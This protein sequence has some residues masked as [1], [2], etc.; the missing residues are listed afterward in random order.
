MEIE[1]WENDEEWGPLR[2]K[3][4]QVIDVV[5]LSM[6]SIGSIF[7]SPSGTAPTSRYRILEGQE[8]SR[9]TYSELF[10]VIGTT[11][12]DGDGASTFNLPD[13]RGKT[14]FGLNISETEFDTLGESGGLKEV[15]L[16]AA[17]SGIRDHAHN[18]GG[19]AEG[20]G[21]IAPIMKTS[22][23]N[24]GNTTGGAINIDGNPA[25]TGAQSATDAHTNMPPYVV[26]NWV[27]RVL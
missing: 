19:Y 23:T 20:A 18:A 2:D 4:N 22:G 1:Y 21:P 12:G 3:V 6:P 10:T 13:M 11:Y 24:F 5:N 14:I 9:T 17:Q 16:T 15:T 27:M 26:F 25:L 8:L 7:A